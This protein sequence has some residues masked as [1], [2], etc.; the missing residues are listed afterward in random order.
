MSKMT[1]SS[2]PLS[3]S[4]TGHT[5]P[6]SIS[7]PIPQFCKYSSTAFFFKSNI[8]VRDLLSLSSFLDHLFSFSL[9][10]RNFF[11]PFLSLKQF[12]FIIV[13]YLVVG[14]FHPILHLV[15]LFNLGIFVLCCF[16]SIFLQIF[17]C[18]F[19]CVFFHFL[20]FISFILSF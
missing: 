3:D 18:F 12:Y 16:L 19:V 13:M 2:S 5:I 17:W 7:S 14:L 1:F 20:L 15:I 9:L 11:F 6:G 4:L 8:A 10:S